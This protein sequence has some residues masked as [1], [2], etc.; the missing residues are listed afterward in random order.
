MKEKRAQ[1]NEYV[2]VVVADMHCGSAH[3]LLPP[4][5]EAREFLPLFLPEPKQVTEC[6]QNRAQQYLYE[7]WLDAMEQV[8]G[9]FDVLLLNGDI[10]H[11]PFSNTA[12][13]RDISL[14]SVPEQANAAYTLLAPLRK[15]A[16]LCYMASGSKWHEGEY[17]ESVHLLAEKLGVNPNPITKETVCKA[18]FPRFD[19]VILDVA[20]KLSYSPTNPVS[21]LQAEIN[22]VILKPAIEGGF[23]NLIIRSHVHQFAECTAHGI[24]AISTPGW[25]LDI[26]HPRAAGQARHR[27][28]DLGLII[29]TIRP[30]ETKRIGWE[31]VRYKHPLYATI[32]I[33]K[34]LKCQSRTST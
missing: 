14:A 31:V 20:H 1:K 8:P 6:A 15:R 11:G 26:E 19:G 9:R 3:G 2:V 34:E 13:T 5:Q 24:A 18:V 16:K 4:F 33:A 29:V 23:P 32:D 10:Q 25:Q 12:G 7:C 17:S 27:L 22:A 28:S 30:E 21:A